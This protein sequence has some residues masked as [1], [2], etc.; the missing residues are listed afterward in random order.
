MHKARAIASLLSVV[1][2]LFVNY[3]SQTGAINNQT[4][5]ALS[6]NY[7]NLF[8]PS[9]YAF[10]IW[11]IIFLS[12]VAFAVNQVLQSWKS[13]SSY[14]RNIGFAMT[15]VNLGNA[16]WVIVWLYELTLLSVLVMIAM[17]IGLVT[18]FIKTS[19]QQMTFRELLLVRW[20]IN[21]YAGWITVATVANISAYL[22][23]L[24]WTGEPL[25]GEFWTI[26][27]ICIALAIYLFIGF[28]HHS[29]SFVAVGAWAL[30]AIYMRHATDQ[31]AIAKAAQI[32]AVA[33][34]F[35]I[36]AKGTYEILSKRRQLI[37]E[38]AAPI[39]K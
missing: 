17:L 15:L 10:A 18:C 32:A 1:L 36:L 22:A 16:A 12:L 24:G 7:T 13:E 38:K 30:Y 11:G 5:G 29:K 23:R 33:L 3:Y 34:T 27:M 9:G 2:V 4:V 26:G 14:H 39:K 6:N 25:S 8:T 31:I 20:P 28:K 37:T 19:Y 35:F 21:I